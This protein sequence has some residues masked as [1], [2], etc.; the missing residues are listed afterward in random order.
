MSGERPFILALDLGGTQFRVALANR[1]GKILRRLAAPTNAKEGRH[2]VVQRI[3]RALWEIVS[4]VGVDAILGMGVS[5]PGPINPKT[6]VLLTPP[7]LPGWNN[8]PLK[9]LWEEE[10]GVPVQAGNDANLAALAE[11]RFGA[12]RG[13]ENIIYITISTGIGG[14]VILDGRPFLGAGGLAGEVG[15]M[16]IDRHG[17]RCRCGNIGCLEALASGTAIARIAAERITSG[18]VSD[19]I[20][21][22]DGDLERITAETVAQAALSGDRLAGEI[23]KRAG[24]D[25]GTGVVNLLHVFNPELVIIGGGVARAGSLIF[26]PVQR[27]VLERAMPDFLVPVVPAALGDDAGLLGAI[28]LV[29]SATCELSP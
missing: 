29:M 2:Q 12:G 19:I 17:P 4:P 7:N 23:I 11:H 22:V 10:F 20:R 14:G 28:A 25:L 3:N 1:Q 5:C 16:T 24:T 27:V 13:V 26:E 18:E 15:H 9:S 8:T 21:L 6:G